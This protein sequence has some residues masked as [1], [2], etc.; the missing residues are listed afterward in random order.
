MRGRLRIPDLKEGSRAPAVV[1][2]HGANHDQGTYYDLA[3]AATK[4]GLATL[5]FDRRG[6]NEDPELANRSAQQLAPEQRG[7]AYRDNGELDVKAAIQF[8]ASQKQV[9]PNR[10]AL[11]AATA[12]VAEAIKGAAGDPRIKTLVMLTVSSM[13][14]PDGAKYLSTSGIPIFTAASSEDV[15]DRGNLAEVTRLTFELSGSKQSH[16]LLYDNVGRGTEMLKYK[17]ELQTMIVRWL[18]EKLAAT[19]LLES[20]K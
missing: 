13:P 1:F 11:V 18:T 4:I 15:N 14:S 2:V 9:D 17:P 7:S 8:M 19:N 12:G 6:K 16:F 5:T 10:I 20:K 3:R